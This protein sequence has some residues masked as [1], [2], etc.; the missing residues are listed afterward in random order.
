MIRVFT[1]LFKTDFKHVPSGIELFHEIMRKYNPEQ[2]QCP[3]PC[4]T[5]G[6]MKQHSKYSRHLV[7][8]DR[9]V[10]DHD[11]SIKRVKCEPCSRT[12]AAIPDVLIPHKTYCIIFI[13][14]VLK[15]YFHTRAATAICKKYGIAI[16]TLYAWR[17][18]YLTHAVL[19]LGA[20]IE[21]ALLTST[22][23][24]EGAADI[25]RSGATHDF[26]GRFGFSF[27]QYI[28]TTEFG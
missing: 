4:K 24:L 28:K 1:I 10:Q 11:V 18:R 26:F 17:D 8:Y 12:H 25:C 9:S 23:W 21:K 14:I 3:P 7:D 16:S 20:I 5:R 2:E 13:L 15:E 6:H 22:R 19:D 27:F